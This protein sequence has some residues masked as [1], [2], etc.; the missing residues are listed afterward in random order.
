MVDEKDELPDLNE[1]L[2][3]DD[4]FGET[5]EGEG[6][7]DADFGD[8]EEEAEESF[9]EVAEN[10]DLSTGG[11]DDF[12]SSEPGADEEA[13]PEA[14]GE[15]TESELGTEDAA[16][17]ESLLG[18]ILGDTEPLPPLQAAA[19]EPAEL[20]EGEAP[21]K[22]KTS[23]LLIL[24]L[25]LAA[26]YAA[27]AYIIPNYFPELLSASAPAKTP[28]PKRIAVK[29]PQKQA[30]PKPVPAEETKAAAVDIIK[31]EVMEPAKAEPMPARPAPVEEELKDKVSPEQAPK[32]TASIPSEKIRIAKAKLPAE[33]GQGFFIQAGAFIFKSNL[34]GPV[35]KIK[36]AGYTPRVET[37]YKSVGM[38]RLT[39]GKWD[40]FEEANNASL[41]LRGLGYRSAKAFPLGGDK[42][43]VLIASYYYKHLAVEEGIILEAKGF[44]TE[45]VKKP[46]KM[47]VYHVLLGPY[48]T[49]EE[50]LKVESVLKGK[51]LETAFIKNK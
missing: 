4:F 50:A 17:G 6:L 42:F 15:F 19:E 14:Q 32:K 41:D 47:K 7:L 3:G 8:A 5:G 49:A 1:D 31:N 51:G 44:D 24:L 33:G 36:A 26:A 13:L 39:A 30:P 28:A 38:N 11:D 48:A 35:S 37:A 2:P 10:E 25:V 18:D 23:P 34:K 43:T 29:P 22:K 45:I 12:F 40:S 16:G 46:V 27:Y 21:K 20:A 9:E